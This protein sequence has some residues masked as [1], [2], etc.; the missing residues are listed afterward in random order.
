[1]GAV[2]PMTKDR[3]VNRSGGW[4]G[5]LIRA[6]GSAT[7]FKGIS[8]YPEQEIDLDIEEQ[9]MTANAPRDPR[10]N[11][12]ANGMLKVI[13]ENMDYKGRR[14]LR[15]DPQIATADPTRPDTWSPE[16]QSHVTIPGAVHVEPG[17]DETQR[18]AA[19]QEAGLGVDPTKQPP[20]GHYQLFEEHATPDEQPPVVPGATIGGEVQEP[21]TGEKVLQTPPDSLEDAQAEPDA[22]F[23]PAERL[24]IQP[25]KPATAPRPVQ[26]G[27]L[28][29]R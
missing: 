20:V 1:M 10:A 12:L 8:L 17:D 2:D 6:T 14:P 11:P 5:V 18:D 7:G 26:S 3:F 22:G 9:A 16:Q 4:L 19:Q 21:D 28:Q 15:P 25:P 24:V 29:G 27:A 23:T 13:A